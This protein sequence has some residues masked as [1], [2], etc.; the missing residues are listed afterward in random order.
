MT[1]DPATL[2]AFAEQTLKESLGQMEPMPGGGSER[3]FFRLHR[4]HPPEGQKPSL[5]GVIGKKE[6]EN[7]AFLGFTRH[8]SEQGLPVPRVYAADE[9]QGIYLMED[10]GGA[11]L[12][13]QLAAWRKN[14]LGRVM[15]M[16]ALTRVV[17]WLPRFQVHGG[18]GL[19][20]NLCYEGEELNSLVFE[21][22]LERFLWVYIPRHAPDLKPDDRTLAEF[23]ILVSRL[24]TVPRDHF[25]YRDFQ[26]R[27][28][29]W[30]EGPV[31]LDYQSGRRG[32]LQYDLASFLYSPDTGLG[33][34][35]RV[36]LMDVYL[37]ALRDCGV[38]VD[39]IAFLAEFHLFVLVRRLQALGAYA[40]LGGKGGK[41]EYLR[42]IP[43]ALAD[44][45]QLQ[46]SGKLNLGLPLLE[47]WLRKLLAR[48]PA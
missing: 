23:D 19:D 29:M 45:R 35:E 46:Q 16:A 37:R 31:F 42:R 28:I 6:G 10:L 32:A 20:Y 27:N 1:A 4:V 14:P 9:A 17:A 33:E 26:T 44:L 34:P 21:A 48:P 7:R 5:V 36:Q 41:P 47:G 30:G 2:K 40:H 3:Q 18:Q 38:T 8:F 25:C 15:A 12:A 24:E 43:P 11:T 13:A 39:R 22:D